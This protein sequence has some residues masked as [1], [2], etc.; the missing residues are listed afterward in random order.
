MSYCR[1]S[2]DGF[3]SDVYCYESD[4]GFVTHVANKRHDRRREIG[5]HSEIPMHEIGLAHDGA[6]FVDAGPREMAETLRKLR[7]EGYRVP[8]YVFGD[9]EKEAI[10]MEAFGPST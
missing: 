2:S 5:D 3:T 4:A 9:L 8:E 6:T 7:E 1:W 10:A